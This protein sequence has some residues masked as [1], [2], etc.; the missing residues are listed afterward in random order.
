VA[1]DVKPVAR[2]EQARTRQARAAVIAAARKLFVEGGYSATTLEAISV[3][4]GVPPATLYRLFASKIGV[5]KSVLDVAAGGDDE[6]VAFGD[7]PDVQARMEYD[8]PREQL[9]A[10]AEL[11]ARVMARL[12]PIHHMLTG[13]AATDP[14]A[15]ELLADFGRQR[16]VGQSRIAASLARRGVLRA[17]VSEREAA[18]TI[19]ALMSPEVFR[20]L[21]VERR[22][23]HR[24]YERWLAGALKELLLDPA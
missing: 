10:F 19:Y 5:L 2:N 23:S 3:A 6:P 8:D 14:E 15:A 13:A 24:N 22:L 18:D 17:G 9:E 4:A 12:A 21:T 11:A 16:Q 20:L 1:G 7:R